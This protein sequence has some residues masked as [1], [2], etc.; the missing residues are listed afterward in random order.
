M[1][2]KWICQFLGKQNRLIIAAMITLDG[3]ESVKITFHELLYTIQ[4]REKN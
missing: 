4:Q 3:G 2:N 1:K